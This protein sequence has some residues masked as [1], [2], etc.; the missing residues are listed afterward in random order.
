MPGNKRERWEELCELAAKEHDTTRL[1]AMVHEINNLLE[2]K[3]AVTA[4][5]PF[6]FDEA[7]IPRRS[8]GGLFLYDVPVPSRTSGRAAH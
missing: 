8:L 6:S 3:H 2:A 7:Q 1:L 5:V 4:G